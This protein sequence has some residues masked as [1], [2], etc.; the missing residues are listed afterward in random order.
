MIVSSLES[1]PNLPSPRLGLLPAVHDANFEAV[2]ALPGLDAAQAKGMVFFNSSGESI[3]LPGYQKWPARYARSGSYFASD[4]RLFYE[5]VN[6]PG[7]TSYYPSSFERTL[8]SFAFDDYSFLRPEDKLIT[9]EIRISRVL[10]ARL[11]ANNTTAQ[12]GVT[13]EC[14]QR[15]NQ[16][17][18][19]SVNLSGQV[20]GDGETVLLA[21]SSAVFERMKVTGAGIEA[22]TFVKKVSGSN[23]ILNKKV[24]PGAFILTFTSPIGPNISHIE[25]LPPMLYV[26]IQ[27]TDLLMTGLFGV[28]IIRYAEGV[29]G[30]SAGF[31]AVGLQYGSFVEVPDASLPTQADFIFRL[32]I[33]DFDTEN[34]VSDP[35]G[36]LGYLMNQPYPP[37]DAPIDW[38]FD[39]HPQPDTF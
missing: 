17:G 1:F 23:V 22:D 27:V 35:G 30:N 38:P 36:F 2:T 39:G 29:A 19:K 31:Y 28:K 25:W 32:R 15:K 7:T 8:Y 20:L 37:R 34:S 4:G 10:N 21:D 14:G 11:I 6:K 33:G 26:S 13:F 5:V 18:G 3:V 16:E 24:T 9:S 12:I